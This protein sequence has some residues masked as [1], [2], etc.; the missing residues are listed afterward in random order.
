MSHRVAF[1]VCQ[2]ADLGS[3]LKAPTCHPMLRGSLSQRVAVHAPVGLDGIKALSVG[4]G[5]GGI[6]AADAA[7]AV[8]VGEVHSFGRLP[9]GSFAGIAT[10][11]KRGRDFKSR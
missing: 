10:M 4:V 5:G 7:H 6:A 3:F 8:R 11:N 2:F 1:N 9:A